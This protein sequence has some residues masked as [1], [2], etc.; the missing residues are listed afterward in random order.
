MT[1]RKFPKDTHPTDVLKILMSEKGHSQRWLSDEIGMDRG[2]LSKILSKQ[3]GISKELAQKLSE[4][5]S[6]DPSL[7]IAEKPTGDAALASL[8]RREAFL[9]KE[10]VLEEKILN[11]A[12][13]RK[14]SLEKELAELRQAIKDQ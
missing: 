1:T 11:Q 10:I 9:E 12:T 6:V 14:A 4:F 8:L 3:L 7:F 13:N 2:N 5:Y